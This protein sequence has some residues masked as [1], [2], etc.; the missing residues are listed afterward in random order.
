M[1]IGQIRYFVAVYQAGSFSQ[2]A[3]DQFI[4]VQA[5]S[6]SIADLEHEIGREL[7]ERKS[8]GVVPTAFGKAF[9]QRALRAL[10]SFDELANLANGQSDVPSDAKLLLGLCAPRFKNNEHVRAAIAALIK[11]MVHAPVEVRL[12]G[13]YAALEQLRQ[14]E[15]D[16]LITI[17]RFDTPFTDCVPVLSSPTAVSMVGTHPL[18]SCATVTLEQLADYPVIVDPDLDFFNESILTTYVERGLKSERMKPSTQEEVMAHFTEHNGYAFSVAQAA[19]ADD[20]FGSVIVAIDPKDAVDVPICLVTSK[21]RKTPLYLK[22][23]TALLGKQQ[24]SL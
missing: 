17:G 6:K 10:S 18:A 11:S 22:A 3:K 14:G 7:F 23:E 4:T 5:V 21:H 15:Y 13:G 12:T 24:I 1:N 19:L 9:Y 16:A 8:R 20:R 2:A